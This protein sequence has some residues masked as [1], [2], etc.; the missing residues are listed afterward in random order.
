M[1]PYS[2]VGSKVGTNVPVLGFYTIIFRVKGSSKPGGLKTEAAGFS[3][4]VVTA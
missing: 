3:E 2:L 4:M 1:T